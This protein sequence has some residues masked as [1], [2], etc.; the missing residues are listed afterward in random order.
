M[1]GFSKSGRKSISAEVRTE[2]DFHRRRLILNCMLVW[3]GW[4]SVLRDFTGL[5][6]RDIRES[7]RASGR[8]FIAKCCAT[9]KH[10]AGMLISARERIASAREPR[11]SSDLSRNSS[12]LSNT[13]EVS[14]FVETLLDG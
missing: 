14:K 10:P 11:F 5:S 8:V 6:G 13:R 3:P 7:R 4:E 12:L 1:K 2:A 9:A